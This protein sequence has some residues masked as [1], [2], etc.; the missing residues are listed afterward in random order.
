MN[1]Q[2][3]ANSLA[4]CTNLAAAV[5]KESASAC[6]DL[7]VEVMVPAGVSAAA[8]TA[9]VEVDCEGIC[10]SSAGGGEQK[11]RRRQ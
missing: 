5:S 1:W 7:A 4:S 11:D 8:V 3:R 2:R 10:G 6:G 9:V